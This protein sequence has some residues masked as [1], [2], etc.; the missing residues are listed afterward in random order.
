MELF[1]PNVFLTSKTKAKESC[2]IREAMF[3]II[4]AETGALPNRSQH[5]QVL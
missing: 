4:F 5:W 3:G 1:L 2:S